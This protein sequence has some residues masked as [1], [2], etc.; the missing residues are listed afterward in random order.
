MPICTKVPMA[1]G[2]LAFIHFVWNQIAGG[3]L[4]ALQKVCANDLSF[5]RP[6]T[7]MR[8]G[9]KAMQLLRP[10]DDFL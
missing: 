5:A 3:A 7:Q 8:R 4:A 9:G 2:L 10:E 6:N 1:V